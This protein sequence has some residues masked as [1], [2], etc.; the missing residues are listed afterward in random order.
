[1]GPLGGDLAD[2]AKAH[3]Q[4]GLPAQPVDGLAEGGDPPHA[5]FQLV[6]QGLDGLVEVEHGGQHIV[7]DVL[8]AIAV[9]VG[10]GDAGGLGGLHVHVV[11]AAA[12]DSDA[13][14]AGELGDDLGGDIGGHLGKDHVHLIA[15]ILQILLEG[16]AG[17][18]DVAVGAGGLQGGLL[19]GVVGPLVI[20]DPEQ[21]LFHE[22]LL[23]KMS[24]CASDTQKVFRPIQMI[25][26]NFGELVQVPGAQDL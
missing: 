26:Q 22:D 15:E 20:N 18:A 7:G 10:H 1:M 24:V 25:F 17:I 4:Q 5:V 23:L 9:Y 21:G 16:D 19:H 13:L 2:V 11:I 3:K 14:A 6:I 8:G 12:K